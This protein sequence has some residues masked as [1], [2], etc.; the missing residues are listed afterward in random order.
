MVN[1]AWRIVPVVAVV[2]LVAFIVPHWR[3]RDG[4][5]I[6]RQW[7]RFVKSV[8]KTP[9]E[10]PLQGLARANALPSFF[11]EEINVQLRPVL[12]N[13]SNRSEL[14]ST[15]AYVRNAVT[16]LSIRTT[17]RQWSVDRAKGS[18]SMTVTVR[19]HV[20]FGTS[21]EP[22]AYEFDVDWV[23]INGKWLIQ[24]LILVHGIESP[25]VL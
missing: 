24:S 21:R 3:D 12:S 5:I 7:D 23:R 15:F 9:E 22:F 6:N 11:T 17:D 25:T 10:A 13:M 18:A 19:G 2:V 20:T 4:R 14:M 16:T 1:I 8:E